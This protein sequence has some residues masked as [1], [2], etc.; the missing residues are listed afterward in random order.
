MENTLSYKDTIQ[1]VGYTVINNVRVVQ[2]TCT[3]PTDNPMGMRIGIVKL[4]PDMYKVHRDQCR[5][6]YATFEDAAYALQEEYIA[7]MGGRT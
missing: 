2:Y 6:D 4:D 3:I 7:R 5:A 1:R